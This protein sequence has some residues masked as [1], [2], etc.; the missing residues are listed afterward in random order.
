MKF[1][2]TG[3][4]LLCAAA[5]AAIAAP[6]VMEPGKNGNALR[7][8]GARYG[9]QTKSFDMQLEKG[10]SVARWIKP[11]NWNHLEGLLSGAGTFSMLL[12]KSGGIYFWESRERNN[13]NTLLWTDKHFPRLPG[14]WTHVVFTYDQNGTAAAYRNGKQTAK[15]VAEPGKAIRILN[16]YPSAKSLFTLGAKYKGLM[17]DVYI[18]NRVLTAAEAA[19]LFNGKAPAGAIASYLMDD[20]AQPGKDSSGK[21]HL[22]PTWGDGK[23]AVVKAV[24]VVTPEKAPKAQTVKEPAPKASEIAAAAEGLDPIGSADGVRGK[25]AVIN[26]MNTFL[27][28]KSSNFAFD[29]GF[30]VSLW[31]KPFRWGHQVGL[32]TDVGSFQMLERGQGDGGIYFWERHTQHVTNGLLWAP[33]KYRIPLNKWT[34]IAFTYDQKGHGIGYRNGKKVAEQLPG[35]E[36]KGQGIVKI[37]NGRGNTKFALGKTYRGEMD[38]VYVY[39]RV[40]S[41]KEIA[42]LCNGKAPSGAAAAYLMDDPANPGKESSGNN[43]QL[44]AACGP[45]GKPAPILGYTV[46]AP[47][48][49]ANDQLVAWTRS[50]MDHSFQRDKL[51]GVKIADAPSADMAGNEYESFQLVLTP[52]RE[53][54]DVTLTVGDFKL[55]NAVCKAEVRAVDYVKLPTPSNIKVPKRG[56]NVYG[57][58]VSVFPGKDTVAGWYPDPLREMPGKFDLKANESKTFFITVKSPANAPAGIYRS[59]AAVKAADG[60]TLD[61]PL[62]IRVRGFSLPAA[63][64]RHSVHTGNNFRSVGL[65]S[66]KYMEEYY[67]AMAPYYLSLSHTFNGINVKFNADNSVELDTAEWDK[68]MELAI[69]K[70]GMKVIFIPTVG[71]YG[72]PKA[73]NISR[74]WEGVQITPG[75][76]KITPEFEVKFGNFIEVFAKHLKAKGWLERA[77]MSLVDEPHTKGD[78]ALGHAVSKLVKKRA[79]GLK[80]MWTKWPTKE[81]IGAADVWIIGALQPGQIKAALARGEKVEQYPNWHMLIDRPA[82]DR[83]MLGFQMYK[84]GLSGVL[85]WSRDSV[86]RSPDELL[87][88]QMR[89][90]DGRVI[91]G[92]GLI[93]YPGKNNIP[94]PSI[95]LDTTRDALDDYEYLMILEKLAAKRPGDPA[96]KEALE[97][98]KNAADK[99]VPC[100]EAEGD[101][102]KTSW[103]TLKW[104]MDHNVL[105]EYRKG[106]MD[107]IEK[108]MK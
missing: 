27:Q 93:M 22:S 26:G 55:G 103:E 78:F 101:G 96:A 2:L 23:P 20:P 83:R 35:Q 42:D 48:A 76:G 38:E 69:N 39:G 30:T 105:L 84:Y 56:A 24:Q 47:A 70:Y 92:S 10:I 29:G 11:D 41:E 88:P 67:A 77:E 89:Y 37:Y 7:F 43:R 49:A 63:L 5:V 75:E 57:E 106:V 52:K 53:L 68:E 14:R 100:Y 12:R 15:A 13:N 31:I 65:V 1:K 44:Y 18:Y 82:M 99:L 28:A 108:L 71:M 91:Y 98:A 51:A 62:S 16:R 66:K 102:L 32:M 3:T 107:R 33:E 50:S 64:D 61:I 74:T 90:P 94:Q 72:L 4:T 36:E 95:R 86:W 87:S 54:K 17:D 104:E 45:Q 73:Q 79:P 9:L 97:Y 85:H 25:S 34:H 40:L 81:G 19:A 60:T 59:V 21:H 46:E 58:S 8:E 80:V 6:P